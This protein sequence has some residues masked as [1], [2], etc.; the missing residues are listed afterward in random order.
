MSLNSLKMGC[1][2]LNL[3]GGTIGTNENVLYNSR[4]YK[5]VDGY[6]FQN[7]FQIP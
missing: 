6:C 4:F 2:H 3:F 7:S 1:V 5:D